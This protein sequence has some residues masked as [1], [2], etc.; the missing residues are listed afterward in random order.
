MFLHYPDTYRRNRGGPCSKKDRILIFYD[1]LYRIRCSFPT[2]HWF[3][4]WDRCRSFL[5]YRGGEQCNRVRFPHCHNVS[6][7][8]H[9]ILYGWYRRGAELL[10]HWYLPWLRWYVFVV[11]PHRIFRFRYSS[12]WPGYVGASVLVTDWL[13]W[14]RLSSGVRKGIPV[15]GRDGWFDW[16][17]WWLHP[18]RL[19]RHLPEKYLPDLYYVLLHSMWCI[20]CCIQHKKEPIGNFQ[21]LLYWRWSFRYCW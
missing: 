21:L 11:H 14:W 8:C 4:D 20:V 18:P 7:D 16:N 12:D 19:L 10:S 2:L 1:W 13:H 5:P 6:R 15:S 3:P 17:H 9:D